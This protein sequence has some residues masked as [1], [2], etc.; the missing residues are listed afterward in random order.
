[1]SWQR[2]KINGR[3]DPYFMRN[4]NYTIACSGRAGIDQRFSLFIEASNTFIRSFDTLNEA[5]EYHRKL[6]GRN[7]E[8]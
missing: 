7:E 2:V 6:T 5:V 4:G 1:M 8:N 3:L